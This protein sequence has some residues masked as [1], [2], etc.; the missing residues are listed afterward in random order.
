M[1]LLLT[2]QVDFSN[3]ALRVYVLFWDKA[4]SVLLAPIKDFEPIPALYCIVP[5]TKERE[6][7]EPVPA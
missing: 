3:R 2:I 4:G 5:L 6:A 1:M 7:T